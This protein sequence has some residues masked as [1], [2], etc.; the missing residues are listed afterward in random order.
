MVYRHENR[1]L[2]PGIGW[3]KL[4]QSTEALPTILQTSNDVRKVNDF[5]YGIVNDIVYDVTHFIQP[6]AR[7]PHQPTL[8]PSDGA[9]KFSCPTP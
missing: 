9:S 1:D 8:L 5:V 7:L 2:E 3:G 4:T 6:T